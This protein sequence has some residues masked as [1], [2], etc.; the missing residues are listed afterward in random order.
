MDPAQGAQQRSKYHFHPVTM[1]MVKQGQS[2][3]DDQFEVDGLL[4]QNVIVIGRILQVE[5]EGM[6][7]IFELCDNTETFKI[8][9]YKKGEN[10][11]PKALKNL[12]VQ[13]NQWVKIMGTVRVFKEQTAIIGN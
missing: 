3:P 11:D 12:N 7:T 5:E 13:E 10:E 9:F 1:L 8:I 4:L 2:T 6:R